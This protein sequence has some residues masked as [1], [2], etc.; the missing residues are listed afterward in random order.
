MP[1]RPAFTKRAGLRGDAVD[2]LF[3]NE[4]KT[5]RKTVGNT[6]EERKLNEDRAWQDMLLRD[7]LRQPAPE[8]EALMSQA[9]SLE[10]AGRLAEAAAIYHR[11]L[12]RPDQAANHHLRS[13]LAGLL[14]LINRR[15]AAA[16]AQARTS[17]LQQQATAAQQQR[18]QQAQQ[19]ARRRQAGEQAGPQAGNQHPHPQQQQG[20][21]PVRQARGG[22]PGRPHTAPAYGGGGAAGGGGGGGGGVAALVGG[23]AAGAVGVVCMEPG[24]PRG[25]K[26]VGPMVPLSAGAYRAELAAQAQADRQ[27][28]QAELREVQLAEQRQLGAVAAREDVAEFQRRVVGANDQLSYQNELDLERRARQEDRRRRFY[29]EWEELRAAKEAGLAPGG[30]LGGADEIQRRREQIQQAHAHRA[31]ARNA[32]EAP[33]DPRAVY[34]QAHG[35]DPWVMAEELAAPAGGG[36]RPAGA[37][38]VGGYQAFQQAYCHQAGVGA[39]A[40][41]LRR[42]PASAGLVAAAQQRQRQQEQQRERTSAANVER[43]MAVGVGKPP[44]QQPHAARRAAAWAEPDGGGGGRGGRGGELKAP[45]GRPDVDQPK[46]P[47][48]PRVVRARQ[49]AYIEKRRKQQ[50]GPPGAAPPGSVPWGGGG[51]Q[52]QQRQYQ[53]GGVQVVPMRARRAAAHTPEP[54]RVAEGADLSNWWPP[55]PMPPP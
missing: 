38:V 45:F 14:A 50:P 18:L 7:E 54:P 47:I 19:Q 13:H 24:V 26:P 32:S 39:A 37:A 29:L 53:Q 17:E 41:G 21:Q 43:V 6:R 55:P 42:R 12:T 11:I 23:G 15:E 31:L 51:R 3:R 52:P 35:H 27:R 36:G 46:V 22:Q 1:C 16:K 30:P 40:A 10:D 5:Y 9:H 34:H 20:Q 8:C 48:D 28:R 2:E 4:I 49:Q 33:Q 44:Q 25:N